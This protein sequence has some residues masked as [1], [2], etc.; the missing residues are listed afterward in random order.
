MIAVISYLSIES[1]T[2][3]FP[4]DSTVLKQLSETPRKKSSYEVVEGLTKMFIDH[5][6]SEWSMILSDIDMPTDYMMS[7]CALVSIIGSLVLPWYFVDTFFGL[8]GPI[9]ITNKENSDFFVNKFLPELGYSSSKITLSAEDTKSIEHKF[10]G[11]LIKIVY[12][13]LW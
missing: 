6:P 7:F 4:G 13:F 1:M 3:Y 10:E 8:A 11:M 12:A 5:S 2:Q 9:V